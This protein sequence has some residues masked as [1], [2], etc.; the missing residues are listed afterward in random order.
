MAGRIIN[1]SALLDAI[2]ELREERGR[3]EEL[4]MFDEKQYASASELFT[5]FNEIMAIIGPHGGAMHHHRWA[6]RVLSL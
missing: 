4:V 5:D 3:G 6:A 2:R 1:E